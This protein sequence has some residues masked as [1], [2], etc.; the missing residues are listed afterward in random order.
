LISP[1]FDPIPKIMDWERANAWRR[2]QQGRVVF[3]N[4]VFDL[5]HPGHVDVLLAS[6]REGDALVVGVNSDASVKRLK[7]GDRPVRTLADRA[8]VLA[9]LAMV[10]AIVGF[11]ED[12]P[13]ELILRLRPD[14][15]VKGGDYTIET[16]IGAKEVREWGGR[17]AIVPLT[18][19]Q[20]TTSIIQRLRG[21]RT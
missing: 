3:T 4:G 20:S 6:R 8:Y 13:L 2:G 19:G 1:L 21:N 18:L 7:G 11:D 10:D 16:V 14:V 15:L 9:A 12:T 5:L 17:V